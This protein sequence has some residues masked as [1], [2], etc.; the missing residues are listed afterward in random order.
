M[1]FG[2]H[3]ERRLV[4][5]DAATPDQVARTRSGALCKEHADRMTAPVGWHLDDRRQPVPQLFRTATGDDSTGALERK[6][7]RRKVPPAAS[8]TPA[9]PT[10]PAAPVES[11]AARGADETL[12]LF[13]L[14]ELEPTPVRA[15]EPDEPKQ[16]EP[17]QEP[18][19]EPEPEPPVISP[20]A[21]VDPTSENSTIAIE[22]YIDELP[23]DDHYLLDNEGEWD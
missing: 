21:V 11:V 13:S 14:E 22:R 18:E 5:I 15:P 1:V 7:R 10:T 3:A 17:K 19:P 4:W 6:A 9:A 12:S 20:F 2:F 16:P 23:D 8:S